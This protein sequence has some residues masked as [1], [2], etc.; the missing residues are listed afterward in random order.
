MSMKNRDTWQ[1]AHKYCGKQFLIF[2]LIMLPLSAA[3]MYLSVG[4][5][6]DTIGF[7]GGAICFVQTI[8]MIVSIVLTEKAL[9]N[10]FDSDGNRR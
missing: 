5:A 10:S 8:P 6:Q 1:F 9:R 3:A 4:A 2:G 7:I